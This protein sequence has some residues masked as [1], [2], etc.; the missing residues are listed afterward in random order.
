MSLDERYLVYVSN[1]NNNKFYHIKPEVRN[2]E[3]VCTY[4]RIGQQGCVKT[5]PLDRYYTLLK[6]KINKGYTDI[7]DNWKMGRSLK[8]SPASIP[9][10][11]KS[12]EAL[13]ELLRRYSMDYYR[14][15]LSVSLGT[16]TDVMVSR[17]EDI[18]RNI[19]AWKDSPSVT[20][21]VVSF[22]FT[23]LYT[24]IP[25]IMQ[26]TRGWYPQSVNDIT[27]LYEKEYE[28]LENL[29]QTREIGILS[30]GKNDENT[31]RQ[32]IDRFALEIAPADDG[33]VKIIKDHLRSVSPMFK[34]AWK[35]TNKTTENAFAKHCHDRNIA[36][37]AHR[38]LWH[39]S[40]NE[41][42]LNILS[43]GLMLKNKA[44]KTGSMFGHGLYF[45]PKARK[46]LGYT[47]ITGS[48]W[49]GGTQTTAYLALYNVAYGNTY[50]VNTYKNIDPARLLSGGYDSLHA[51]SDKGML[52]NDEIVVYSDDAATIRYL[53]EIAA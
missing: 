31:N 5:Y 36:P 21:Q 41:N 13:I 37:D 1:Q 16:I 4:G 43:F 44:V 20:P 29:K 3:I 22:L 30:S 10:S 27:K 6:E 39:G 46:S 33:D 35:V 8:N 48:T 45:A 49:A 42:W 18:L 47:S 2:D 32:I 40:R 24:N 14:D 25:R 50:H 51:H 34:R 15:N 53:V 11:L 17:Q 7:T 19:K 38:L 12:D 23:Q 28:Y 9:S 52:L 26:D